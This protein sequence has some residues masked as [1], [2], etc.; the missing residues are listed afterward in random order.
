MSDWATDLATAIKNEDEQPHDHSGGDIAAEFV[1]D[2]GHVS[3]G[4]FHHCNEPQCKDPAE[5]I[6]VPIYC[7]MGDAVMAMAQTYLCCYHAGVINP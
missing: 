5:Y 2:I 7:R 1:I 6:A 3:D 4:R